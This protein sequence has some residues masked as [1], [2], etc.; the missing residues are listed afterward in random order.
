MPNIVLTYRCNLRC[1]YCFANEYVNRSDRDMSRDELDQAIEFITR[2]GPS[3]MGL[4]GGEPLLHPQAAEILSDIAQNE[5]IT[6][7]T[8]FTNGLLLGRFLEHLVDPKFRL[9]VNCNSPMLIGQAAFSVLSDNL[10]S[11][12][13]IEGMKR[14]VN[15]GINLFD[16]AQDY[17]YIIELLTRHGLHRVRIS[18]T[19]PDF[20]EQAPPAAIDQFV[21]RKPFLLRFLRDLD[22]ANVLPYYDCNKPPYCIWTEPEREWLEATV[23]KYGVVESNLIGYRSICYP[24]LDILPGLEVV[25]CFGVGGVG[26]VRMDEFRSVPELA[27][28]FLGRI[29]APAYQIAASAQCGSCYEHRIRNCT[30]GCIGYKQPRIELLREYASAL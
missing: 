29:D 12:F 9:L 19:V 17:S 3:R 20:G 28:Y 21:D 30:A 26:K 2:E 13:A 16:D 11:L 14:R 6:E 1:P 5:D 23:A 27:N 15:L 24:T 4:I 10:D 7:V 25:R 22:A 18:L 8:V